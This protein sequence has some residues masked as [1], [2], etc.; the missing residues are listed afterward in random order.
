MH[1]V[2][3]YERIG[4]IAVLTVRNP[5]VNALS[6]PVRQGLWDRMDQA[7]A[8]LGVRAAMIVGEGRAFFA[9][10][11]ITEFGKPLMEPFLPDLI[12]RIE[13]SPLIVVAAMH[14]VSLGG[15]LE[16]ALGCHYR[17]AV[18]S[19]RVGLPEVH[20][21]LIPGAGGTQR[22]PRLTGVDADRK[23]VV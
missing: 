14:G 3:G 13:A 7:E 22:L 21:G 10:A 9:G 17:I 2:I 20:L 8:D 12:Q 19:A 11:D 15:G 4:D 23:S 1:D 18:P 5:P 16:V 6:Q